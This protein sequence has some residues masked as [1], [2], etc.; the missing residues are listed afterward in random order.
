M[1]TQNGHFIGSMW[2]RKNKDFRI[3]YGIAVSFAI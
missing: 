3:N 1:R 2:Q